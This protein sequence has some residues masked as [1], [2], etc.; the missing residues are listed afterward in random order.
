VEARIGNTKDILPGISPREAIINL[1][2]LRGWGLAFQPIKNSV[3][4]IIDMNQGKF[5]L[6]RTKLNPKSFA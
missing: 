6:G 3:A 1:K 4:E 5:G 2:N